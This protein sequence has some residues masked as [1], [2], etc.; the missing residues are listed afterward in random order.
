MKRSHGIYLSADLRSACLYASSSACVCWR[1]LFVFGCGARGCERVSRSPLYQEQHLRPGEMGQRRRHS[2]L[3]T[4]SPCSLLELFY[5]R[6]L[7]Y[8]QVGPRIK[9]KHLWLSA[10]PAATWMWVK[11][12]K[13]V[14][15][16]VFP[17]CGVF[18]VT[19]G[20]PSKLVRLRGSGAESGQSDA[21]LTCHRWLQHRQK[22]RRTVQTTSTHYW[23]S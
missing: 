18:C 23:E 1:H 17:I 4:V 12:A 20:S 22:K 21:T 9:T 5:F 3:L 15:A 16:P 14:T 7:F 6:R 2:F 8:S 11:L 13:S 10:P 19:I